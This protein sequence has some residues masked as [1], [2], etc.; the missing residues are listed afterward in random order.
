M[1]LPTHHPSPFPRHFLSRRTQTTHHLSAT[2]LATVF[3]PQEPE[4]CERRNK[5]RARRGYDSREIQRSLSFTAAPGFAM[6]T[7]EGM[8]CFGYLQHLSQNLPRS[9][10]L[11][12]SSPKQCAAGNLLY[13]SSDAVCGFVIPTKHYRC[14]PASGNIV[15]GE[16][17]GGPPYMSAPML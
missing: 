11:Q 7:C 14:I 6:Q 10:F 12:S 1:S 9:L 3:R 2:K 15:L 8:D 5:D 13:N 4:A 17:G 16:F